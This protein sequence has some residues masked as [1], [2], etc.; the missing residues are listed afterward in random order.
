ME[1]KEKNSVS[2]DCSVVESSSSWELRSADLDLGGGAPVVGDGG[3]WASRL[4]GKTVPEQAVW[5]AGVRKHE[6]VCVC[7]RACLCVCGCMCV[8][9]YVSVRMH[10]CMFVHMCV[11]MHMSICV[12][13]GEL[14]PILAKWAPLSRL[15]SWGEGSLVPRTGHGDLP[16][17]QALSL[18]GFMGFM[19]KVLY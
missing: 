10:V 8:H 14:D 1:K 15:L 12:L 5:M 11:Y 7:A 2:H 6:C 17:T 16:S 13:G 4:Q 3:N 18:G 19:E 9:T